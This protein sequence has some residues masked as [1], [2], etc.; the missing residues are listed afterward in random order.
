MWLFSIILLVF[1]LQVDVG[2]SQEEKV[3]FNGRRMFYFPNPKTA[4]EAFVDCRTR[5]L[6]MMTIRIYNEFEPLLD[7]TT[8]LQINGVLLSPYYGNK[9]LATGQYLRIET[10]LVKL[11]CY[12]ID[13]D[14]QRLELIDCNDK[15]PYLCVKVDPELCPDTS[16][17]Q[18]YLYC[19]EVQYCSGDAAIDRFN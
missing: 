9:W 2:Q 19:P 14:G 12:R 1:V 15:F 10:T 7:Y 16:R 8:D 11:T 5:G 4:F 18:P 3:P 13:P 17:E 6:S